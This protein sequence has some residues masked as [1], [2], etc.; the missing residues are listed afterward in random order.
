[1]GCLGYFSDATDGR[2]GP[3]T[4]KAVQEYQRRNGLKQDGC[5]GPITWSYLFPDNAVSSGGN[6]GS[7]SSS[8]SS[9]QSSSS[10]SGGQSSSIRKD[11]NKPSPKPSSKRGEKNHV[12]PLFDLPIKLID[13]QGSYNG[14]IECLT[15][16]QNLILTT[17]LVTYAGYSFAKEVLTIAITGTFASLA[18][19]SGIT[20]PL[21]VIGFLSAVSTISYA[22]WMIS[23]I[24]LAI[25]YTNKY[26]KYTVK[27][28][29][30]SSMWTYKVLR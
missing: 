27:E 10:S 23:Q 6:S 24:S 5:V 13:L 4:K 11:S 3:K 18:L 12:K 25:E 17:L 21:G 14:K 2:F 22:N 26:K 19:A 9:N 1:M 30:K 28:I 20:V 29:Y 8:S 7:G 16:I 15:G